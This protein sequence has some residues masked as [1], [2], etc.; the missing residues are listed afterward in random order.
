MSLQK[1]PVFNVKIYMRKLFCKNIRTQKTKCIKLSLQSSYYQLIIKGL[2]LTSFVKVK[3]VIQLIWPRFHFCNKRGFL[4]VL[5]GS[6]N[7]FK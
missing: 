1:R 4:I 5:F 7:I 6:N 3:N 2:V